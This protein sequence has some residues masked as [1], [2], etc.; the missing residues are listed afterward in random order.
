MATAL[1]KMP[2]GD[3]E[4]QDRVIRYLADARVRRV[5]SEDV[6]LTEAEAEKAHRFSRFLTRRFYRDR[7]TR[8]FRH[9][10]ALAAQI[11]R[12]VEELLVA[13]EFDRFVEDCRMGSFECAQRRVDS[14]RAK[15]RNNRQ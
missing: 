4:L 15:Q 1:R 5:E 7:L 10:G 11:G 3:R 9:S 8:A 13:P 14:K 6:P 2:A 12:R